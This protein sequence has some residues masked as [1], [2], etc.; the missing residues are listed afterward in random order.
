MLRR[1]IGAVVA[2]IAATLALAGPAFARSAD[3]TSAEVALRL[4]PDGAL[5]V[6]ERLAFEYDG[7]FEGSYRDINLNF[8]ETDHRRPGEPG[9]SA[10]RARWQHRARQLRP[11]RRLRHRRPRRPLS[12][13]LALPGDRRDPEHHPLV[14]GRGRGDRL[15]GHPRR[16]LGRLG[17]AVG[18][19][20]RPPQRRLHQP[21]ARHRRP[22]V[23][24]LGPHRRG[25]GRVRAGRGRDLAR[26]RA[27]RRSRP[28]TCR[29][30]PRSSSG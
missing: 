1:L 22:P 25:R 10:V 18:V 13:R 14:P 16:H 2:A 6:T 20:P 3:I 12:D 29:P 24:G 11:A 27:R 28:R 21:G 17:G 30:G 7:H 9:R 4:A 23:P 26:A 15:R 19:R 8:G 5:L